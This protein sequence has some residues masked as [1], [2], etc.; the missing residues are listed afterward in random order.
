MPIPKVQKSNGSV[1]KTIIITVLIATV[2]G[3]SGWGLANTFDNSKDITSLQTWK[4]EGDRFTQEE[5]TAL[6]TRLK[7]LE[8][9]IAAEETPEWFDR[10]FKEDWEELKQDVKE[11]SNKTDLIWEEQIKNSARLDAIDKKN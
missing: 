2:L 1:V 4:T 5:G 11:I 6:G 8:L 7:T 10:W 9:I 3:L